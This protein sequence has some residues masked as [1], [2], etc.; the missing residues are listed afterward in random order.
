M[1]VEHL[2]R[3]FD[4]YTEKTL[5]FKKGN[6]K[7]LVPITELNGVMSLCKLYDTLA[8]LE[9]GVRTTH[10][11]RNTHTRLFP[12]KRHRADSLA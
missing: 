9:N 4:A 11:H 1:E 6:C 10:T 12:V 8:T 2:Q 7:E 5:L 3:L